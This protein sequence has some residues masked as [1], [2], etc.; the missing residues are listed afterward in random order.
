MV[1][2]S[3]KRTRVPGADN[4]SDEDW[5]IRLGFYI[6]DASRLRR[7]VYDTALR[8]LGVTRSQ[9]W[10]IAYLSRRDGMAQSELANQLDL[11]KVA[12][13]GLVDRLETSRLIERRAHDGDR[14][15]KQ[16]FLTAEGRKV[17]AKMRKIASATNAR[18]LNGVSARD[19]KATTRILRTVKGNLL[20]MVNGTLGADG[21]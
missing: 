21:D 14:R 9:A 10:V 6:H 7:I 20:Q 12:L 4:R 8:P 15:V 5:A 2:K 11:G 1:V 19:V 17:V 16:I 3:I 18:I 13:G